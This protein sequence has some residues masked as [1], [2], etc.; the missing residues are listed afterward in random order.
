M[1]VEQRRYQVF[2]SST[3]LD[4]KEER[5]AIVQTLLES[6]AFPAGM[7]MFP[8]SDEDA[9]GLITRVIND[10]DYYLLVIGGKYGS[11]DPSED[12]S[13]TEKEFNYACSIGKPVMAFLHGDPSELKVGQ[14]E[15][16]E[17]A[18]EKLAAFREKVQKTKHVK[19]WT[20]TDDLAGKVAL[21]F[22][23][24][25]RALPGVGWVRGDQAASREMLE[26]LARAKSRIEVLEEDLLSAR[27]SAPEGSDALSQG[28]DKLILNVRA[29]AVILGKR[30]S[31]WL[32][33]PTTWNWLLRT[34][35]PLLLAEAS[36]DAIRT[37]MTENIEANFGVEARKALKSAAAKDGKTSGVRMHNYD[38]VMDDNSFGTVLL[39][40]KA[41]GHIEISD[42]RRSVNDKG[43]YWRLTQFGESQ[44]MHLRAV[45]RAENDASIRI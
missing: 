15:L 17:P 10:S 18:R 43:T 19:F 37:E 26:E 5:L 8:A 1:S 30:Y 27:N 29:Q 23:K 31:E 41:L 44:A 16:E 22:N 25:Q 34:I 11:V 35:S 7:E 33:F 42:Q 12:I 24:L 36:Q 14:S 32:D 20:T 9:W 13:Y 3:Y 40:L 28:D 6:D 39:Q 45:K 21:S 38:L 4:L 2:I